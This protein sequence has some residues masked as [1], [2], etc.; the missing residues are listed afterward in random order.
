MKRGV[1]V[2]FSRAIVMNKA[3]RM[4]IARRRNGLGR[5]AARLVFFIFFDNDLV[6]LVEVAP[7]FW[8]SGRVC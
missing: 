6:V 1:G 5:L 2:G 8:K 4:R 3:Q 7:W